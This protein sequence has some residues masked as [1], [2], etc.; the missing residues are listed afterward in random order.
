[1]IT[2]YSET[3]QK[4]NPPME[5]LNGTLIPYYE[6]PERIRIILESISDHGLGP[7]QS[8]EP[9]DLKWIEAIHTNEYMSF[10]NQGY[11]KWVEAGGDPNGI[12]PSALAVR[13]MNRKTDNPLASP[14]Y[15]FFD[16]S[17][18][19]VEGT[20]E[21]ALSAVHVA[22]TGAQMLEEGV[23]SVYALCRPPGHH[24]GIDLAG[25]YCF[26]NNAAVAAQYLCDQSDI[27]RVAILD[28][29]I[30]HGN[31]TQQIFYARSDVVY[32][33]LHIDPQVEY[34]YFSGYSDEMG[35]G[36]GI[37]CNRNLPLAP[38]TENEA[39][40]MALDEALAYTF[41]C[42]PDALIVSAGFDTYIHDPLGGFDLTSDIYPIIGQR[43]AQMALPTLFIQEGGY[44]IEALGINVYGLLSGYEAT[45]S[46]SA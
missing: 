30:H 26:M 37:G 39:Y 36:G 23:Q 40:L 6:T 10:L 24:A 11:R 8:P 41:S 16:L 9:F 4:H 42:K 29:D 21:A 38:H 22:L 31:G 34:P 13:H 5:F 18:P 15:Y 12:F 33:S 19:I 27:H 32:T 17:A 46:K 14:G 28:I 7:I 20:Y 3:H 1:M 45:I 44:A 43:I 2:L 35:S 25:G